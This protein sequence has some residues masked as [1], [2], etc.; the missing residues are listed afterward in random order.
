LPLQQQD[1]AVQRQALF[2]QVDVIEKVALGLDFLPIF[3]FITDQQNRF[4]WVNQAFA[5]EI[6]NPMQQPLRSS[7]RFVPAAIA[8]P[9]RDRFPRWK[10]EIAQCLSGLYEQV[11][12][13]NLNSS[14][15]ELIDSTLSSD[16]ALMRAAARAACPW[17]GTML[18]R[19]RS[20]SQSLIREKVVPVLNT[21]GTSTG[22]H[23]SLWFSADGDEPAAHG[24]LGSLGELTARQF[25]IAK[26]FATGLTAEEI[27]AALGISWHTTRA[28]LE[29]IYQRLSVH[30]KTELLLLLQ[31]QKESQDA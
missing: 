24:S 22:F 19:T 18:V 5:R 10:T 11:D 8:G 23:V 31:R 9:F 15:L 25:E 4:V 21:G 17:D 14:V 16:R 2:A 27:A 7:E 30:T 1:G 13:G 26:L 12:L 20:G 28:H 6:G 3:A 29:H